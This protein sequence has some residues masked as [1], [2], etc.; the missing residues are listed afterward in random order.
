MHKF[1]NTPVLILGHRHSGKRTFIDSLYEVS[2]TE[3]TKKGKPC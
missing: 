2:K 1:E 3:L